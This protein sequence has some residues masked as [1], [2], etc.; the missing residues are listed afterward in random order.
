M[1]VQAPDGKSIDFG[2][3]PADQVQ[4]AMQKLYPPQPNPQQ[5]MV[6]QNKYE[7]GDGMMGAAKQLGAYGMNAIQGLPG[8]TFSDEIV[9]GLGSMVPGQNYDDLQQRQQAFRQAGRELQ[10]EATAM[11]TIGTGLAGAPFMPGG[12]AA[13]T[14]LGAVAKGGAAGAAYGAASGAGEGNAFADS[15]DSAVQ[16]TMNAGGGAAFGGALGAATP[17][18][19]GL[20]RKGAQGMGWA[21]APDLPPAGMDIKSE[22][23]QYY[24]QAKDLGA[25]YSPNAS[26]QVAG[27]VEKALAATGKNNARLHGDT[28]SVL[29]DLKSASRN[30][31]LSLEELD[32]FRQ[33][34]GQV[35]TKNVISNPADAFKANRAI[36][37]I[38][39]FVKNSGASHLVSGDPAAIDALNQGRSMWSQAAKVSDVEKIMSH[40][41]MTDNPATS[42]KTGFRTL[43]ENQKRIGGYS[44]EERQ[45]MKNIATSNAGLDILRTF[46]SRLMGIVSGATGA[47]V[48]GTAA[49]Q[50]ISMASRGAATAMQM[51]KA[52][53]LINKIGNFDAPPVDTGFPI[54]AGSTQGLFEL[55]RNQ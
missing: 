11:G 8:G 43:L 13:K 6:A 21:D 20:G 26:L 23:G 37:A 19:M 47:G 9:S 4:S 35:S 17:A 25:V 18:L 45:I 32:Q 29:D 30:G 1:I 24:K 33:L 55:M 42:I 44:P 50:G 3:M 40:A 46:G 51:N 54:T 52:Q 10:P 49:A 15:K 41:D 31:N 39:D 14:L 2:E 27:D 5:Q 34:F 28:L 16:R 22:A 53:G 38:D 48:G 36:D 12:G 7:M